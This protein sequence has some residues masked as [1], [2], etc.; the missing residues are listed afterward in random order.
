MELLRVAICDDDVFA[1]ELIRDAVQKVM[2]Q[3]KVQGEIRCFTKVKDLEKKMTTYSFDLLLLDI[4]M[5][6][7]DGISFAKRLRDAKSQVDIIY[8]SSREDRVFDSLKVN[9]FGFIR[10][11]RF[12]E[13]VPSV[14]GLYL[15]RRGSEKSPRIVLQIEN[16]TEAVEVKNVLYIEG[17]RK[18]QQI[19]ITGH[20]KPGEIRYSMQELEDELKPAGFLRVHKGYLVNYRH[21]RVF[22]GS[23]V[24]LDNG[25][26]IPV[27][28]RKL[29]E[30]KEAYMDWMR[31]DGNLVVGS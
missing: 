15:E 20:D 21:I 2:N 24:L 28:R 19:Y 23:D 25:Q 8:V 3:K 31:G 14:L 12:L 26:R 6:E 27:S 29:Q 5:P 9:P 10:K 7:T 30:I 16:R 13:D 4:D 18:V 22:E 11:N 1:L 17:A